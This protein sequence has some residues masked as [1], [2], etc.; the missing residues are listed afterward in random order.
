MKIHTIALA[1]VLL[2]GSA[3]AQEG[4]ARRVDAAPDGEV[5]IAF[6]SKPGVCGWENGISTSRNGRVS[7]IVRSGG[8]R[9]SEECVEGPVRVALVKRGGR[10]AELETRV[11]RPFRDRG[12]RVTDLG[13]VDPREASAYLLSLAE[14]ATEGEVGKDA[15]FPATIAQGAVTWPAL[16]RIAR[17]ESVPRRTREGA[18]FWL[19]S[20]AGEAATRGLQEIAEY[21]GDQEVRKHAVFA[22]SRRPKDEA[23]PALIRIART[24][25]DP[26]IRRTALF[27][28]GRL[29]DPRALALFEE[30][31]TG[32]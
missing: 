16:L 30:L 6:T 13:T 1:S 5:H 15:I 12:R 27:W 19:S 11:G 20:E 25:R 26:E 32:K 29:D 23:V 24:H 22:L 21:D 28:L 2:A 4:I 18:V 9:S 3:A 17:R 14:R 31:L 10:V 7:Q 8:I